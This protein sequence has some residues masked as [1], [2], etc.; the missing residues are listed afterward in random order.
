M[1]TPD[2]LR[3]FDPLPRP[4][5]ERAARGVLEMME[6]FSGTH[7]EV[8]GFEPPSRPVLYATNSTQRN[9]FLALRLA[10]A[11]R[12]VKVTTV[13]K[14]RTYHEGSGH[15]AAWLGTIPIASRGYVLLVDFVAVNGRRPTDAEYRLLRDHVDQGTALPSS[16]AFGRLVSVPRELLGHAVDPACEPYAD[17]VHR[18]YGALMQETL[19]LMRTAVARGHSIQLYPEGTVSPR[20]GVG[21]IG[22][23]QAAHALG[24]DIVPVG[25]SGCPEVIRG[26]GLLLTGG[27]IRLRFGEPLRHPLA[28]LPEGFQAFEPASERAH[29]PALL[30]ATEVLMSRLDGLL[31]ERYRRPAIAPRKEPTSTHRFL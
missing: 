13:T 10:L 21:R 30:A 18:V 19:R 29:R 2:Y 9:D 15:V 14:A 26:D 3:S 27:T 23:V 8:E 31:D 28:T 6:R 1:L 22:A 16:D 5:F 17:A 24:L 4:T 7:L 25:M 20:L 11:R 12:A